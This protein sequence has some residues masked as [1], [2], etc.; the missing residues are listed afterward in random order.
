MRVKTALGGIKIRTSRSGTL[1]HT[2]PMLLESEQGNAASVPVNRN[3]S[4]RVLCGVAELKVRQASNRHHS[5]IF[6]FFTIDC[7]LAIKKRLFQTTNV[8]VNIQKQ[9][10][11][12]L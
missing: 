3:T 6:N 7:V 5:L 10:M 2:F 11:L 4:F 8:C 9:G 12:S 1:I